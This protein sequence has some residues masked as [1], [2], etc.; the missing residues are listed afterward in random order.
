MGTSAIILA[1]E[2]HTCAGKPLGSS[3]AQTAQAQPQVSD[4]EAATHTFIP[5]E[6][7]SAVLISPHRILATG[8]VL[9]DDRVLP[10]TVVRYLDFHPYPPV[11]TQP[12]QLRPPGKRKRKR[13]PDGEPSA[14]PVC[15]MEHTL[16]LVPDNSAPSAA[17]MLYLIGGMKVGGKD[18]GSPCKTLFSYDVRHAVWT[19]VHVE[20]CTGKVKSESPGQALGPRF[21]HSALYLASLRTETRAKARNAGGG[22]Y[23]LVYGGYESMDAKLPSP[24][25]HLFDVRHRR[26]TLRRP[27]VGIEAPHRAYHASAITS[28]GAYLVVHGG[29][30]SHFWDTYMLS[31]DLYVFD[32]QGAQWFRPKLLPSSAAPPTARRRHCM[33]NG[34]GRHKGNLVLF[35]GQLADATYSNDLFVLTI[36]PPAGERPVSA[37]WQHVHVHTPAPPLAP[38]PDQQAAPNGTGAGDQRGPITAVAGG[39]L[40]AIPTLN[41]YLFL[42]G[43]GSYGMQ[44]S[45]L[46]LDATE[47]EQLDRFQERLAP[48]RQKQRP[49]APRLPAPAALAMMDAGPSVLDPDMAPRLRPLKRPSSPDGALSLRSDECIKVPGPIRRPRASLKNIISS[50]SPSLDKPPTP[51]A[52]PGLVR[53]GTA[54]RRRPI[55]EPDK[56][57]REKGASELQPTTNVRPVSAVNLGRKPRSSARDDSIMNLLNDEDDEDFVIPRVNDLLGDNDLE[58]PPTKRKRFIRGTKDGQGKS[59]RPNAGVISDS[60]DDKIPDSAGSDFVA[61]SELAQRG[62]AHD[63]GRGRGRGRG[64]GKSRAGAVAEA[65]ETKKLLAAEEESNRR[66]AMKV[67][68]LETRL[69]KELKEKQLID[70]DNRMLNDQLKSLLSEVQTLRLSQAAMPQVGGNGDIRGFG[71]L[72]GAKPN[73]PIGNRANPEAILSSSPVRDRRLYPPESE[74][75]RAL[76]A[77]AVNLQEECEELGAQMEALDRSRNESEEAKRR[78]ETELNV[79]RNRFAKMQ[80]EKD[81]FRKQASELR[82]V[83]TAA[84]VAADDTNKQLGKE[85]ETNAALKRET[86]N[87]KRVLRDEKA[88]REE[89]ARQ[90]S[91]TQRQLGTLRAQYDEAQRKYS[92]FA[93]IE[94]RLN[95]EN[96]H[97]HNQLRDMQNLI[98]EANAKNRTLEDKNIELQ[99]EI[100][101]MKVDLGGKL[102]E[103]ETIAREAEHSRHELDSEK[104]SAA[105]LDFETTRLKRELERERKK[106]TELSSFLRKR[107]EALQALRPALARITSEFG[108]IATATE[109]DLGHLLVNDV[110]PERGNRRTSEAVVSRAQGELTRQPVQM[111]GLDVDRK[112]LAMPGNGRPLQP[113]Q[114]GKI[115]VAGKIVMGSEEPSEDVDEP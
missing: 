31:S 72:T 108:A 12:L 14:V 59:S 93:T 34:I 98:T 79:M 13:G 21:A 80:T 5:A 64:R 61:A 24:T 70:E 74:E 2:L 114:N 102:K 56:K 76:R 69:E 85:E 115:A 100:E 44:N 95:M 81:T 33:V 107:D 96:E 32:I 6:G 66:N 112:E 92:D 40:L 82:S 51:N 30:C 106:R 50:E 42:G 46:L 57:S 23:I 65:L 10:F 60:D 62:K 15:R 110:A 19:S 37:I 45:P 77:K 90:A 53:G 20:P 104:K 63:V 18:E 28:S 103:C 58:T 9:E 7:I 49:A 113:S 11:W 78:L 84:T 52:S 75:L 88:I 16:T 83:A 55:P 68:E 4:T 99:T 38:V 3:N 67:K 87:L 48:T 43:R 39:T 8:G 41:K 71:T 101:S 36:L 35:G 27:R 105:E 111:Q 26:W 1:S 91:K 17:P 29:S 97:L 22:G 89:G 25:V 54:A 94:R 86:E 109:G 73:C 47:A